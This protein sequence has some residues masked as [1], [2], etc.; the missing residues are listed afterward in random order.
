MAIA[1]NLWSFAIT[2]VKQDMQYNT[3]INLSRQRFWDSPIFMMHL[4]SSNKIDKL[5]HGFSTLSFSLKNWKS[6]NRLVQKLCDKNLKMK[7][8]RC[9]KSSSFQGDFGGIGLFFQRLCLRV[10][11]LLPTQRDFWFSKSL[12]IYEMFSK[13]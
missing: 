8:L 3:T 9:T 13:F 4:F 7:N 2:P 1:G 6:P 12:K 11:T 10:I 5:F